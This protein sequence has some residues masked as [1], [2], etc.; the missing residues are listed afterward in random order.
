MQGVMAIFPL[1]AEAYHMAYAQFMTRT[2]P[3]TMC[4]LGPAG[5]RTDRGGT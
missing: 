3:G 2:D 1:T 5:G 4:L